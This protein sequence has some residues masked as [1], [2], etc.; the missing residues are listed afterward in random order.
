MLLEV[1][2]AYIRK[3]GEGYKMVYIG[4]YAPGNVFLFAGEDL[5]GGWMPS[6]L[7]MEKLD[8]IEEWVEPVVHR[9]WANVYND[10]IGVFHSSKETAVNAGR[11]YASLATILIEVDMSKPVGQRVR[12]IVEV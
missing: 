11:Q 8:L 4:P 5:R 7:D 1:G 3:G 9:M 2:K 6:S 12:E 10:C